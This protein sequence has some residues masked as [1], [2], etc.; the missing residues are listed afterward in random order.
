MD[1]WINI[2]HNDLFFS[3][4]FEFYYHLFDV[5]NKM[6]SISHMSYIAKYLLL[7]TF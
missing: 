6:C 5:T 7:K 3:S 2:F 4:T 1:V